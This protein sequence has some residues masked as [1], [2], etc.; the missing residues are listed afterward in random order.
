MVLGRLEFQRI[1]LTSDRVIVEME[2]GWLVVAIPTLKL[3]SITLINRRNTLNFM[4]LSLLIFD[5]TSI[6]FRHR[7][8]YEH[9]IHKVILLHSTE[10]KKRKLV[11]NSLVKGD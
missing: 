3:C 9:S 6:I 7:L 11:D 8:Q 5:L 1:L 2:E 10:E 4:L